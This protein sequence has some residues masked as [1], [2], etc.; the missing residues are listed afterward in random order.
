MDE[1]GVWVFLGKIYAWIKTS[2]HS[3][4]QLSEHCN[5]G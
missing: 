1:Y 2:R 3:L 4:D 5:L